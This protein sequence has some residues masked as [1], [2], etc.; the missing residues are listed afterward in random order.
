[1]N[2]HEYGQ[3]N[4][5]IVVILH[6]SC[7]AY[8]M[9]E[10]SI[11]I[12]KHSFHVI[13][14]A[15]PGYDLDT[16]EDFTSVEEVV[17]KLTDW[18]LSHSFNSIACLYGLSMGGSMV[19]R[20]L[21]ESRLKVETAVVDGGITPYDYPRIL[22]RLIAL[23]DYLTVQLGRFNK[24]LLEFAFPVE[25][26]SQQGLDY[27]FQVM[28]HMSSRTIWR[29]F[30]SC[31]NYS[32][33]QPIPAV[34][35][36]C[37]YWYGEKEKKA[38]KLDIAYVKKNFPNFVFREIPDMEHAEYGLMHPQSFADDLTKLIKQSQTA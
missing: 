34:S 8:D 2:F 6:G 15:L 27:M 35:A 19:L 10:E 9:Y 25:K 5:K 28:Q 32:M 7:M 16:S 13:I 26:Y 30:D 22:T 21:A 33:P 23:R 37:E 18:L 20:I 17:L 38:R 31:N 11:E 1:M 14:P 4:K 36:K 3:Q 29:S 24:R 12:L